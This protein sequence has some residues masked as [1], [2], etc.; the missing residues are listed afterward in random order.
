MQSARPSSW[1]Q[2]VSHTVA[3]VDAAAA[4]CGGHSAAAAL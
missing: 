1:K 4:T 2:P 3:S